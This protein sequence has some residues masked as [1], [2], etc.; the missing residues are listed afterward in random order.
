MDFT[1]LVRSL[2]ADNLNFLDDLISENDVEIIKN[3]LI[4]ESTIMM[5]LLNSP[6]PMYMSTIETMLEII[7]KTSHGHVRNIL[8]PVVK[9]A[10]YSN[11]YQK[12][13]TYITQC[14]EF[15]EESLSNPVFIHRLNK[16]LRQIF[17]GRDVTPPY[18]IMIANIKNLGDVQFKQYV[19]SMCEVGASV[20]FTP[21]H[22]DS[23]FQ[24]MK[25][26]NH[27]MSLPQFTLRECMDIYLANLRSLVFDANPTLKLGLLESNDNETGYNDMLFM[28]ALSNMAT[29]CEE[30]QSALKAYIEWQSNELSKIVYST[31]MQV[32]DIKSEARNVFESTVIFINTKDITCTKELIKNLVSIITQIPG[33]VTIIPGLISSAAVK[34]EQMAQAHPTLEQETLIHEN[35]DP[36]PEKLIVNPLSL[37]NLYSTP[38]DIQSHLHSF[39]FCNN[40]GS[41]TAMTSSSNVIIGN[42]QSNSSSFFAM[43]AVSNK[44]GISTR[45][46]RQLI[47]ESSPPREEDP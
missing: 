41:H 40:G 10:L 22:A 29:R 33:N 6:I 31:Y 26:L 19:T 1:S 12:M 11:R 44:L 3:M 18:T 17:Q 23:V 34:F 37:N 35:V 25:D 36:S 32:P 7:P 46:L 16:S 24:H 20:N 21:A 42:V 2:H 43:N 13:D 30:E 9:F 45:E 47:D 4:E 14:K 15:I 39:I 8:V 27:V 38:R 5:S 28:M